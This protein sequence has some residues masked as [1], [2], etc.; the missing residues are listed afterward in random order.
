MPQ[1]LLANVTK[2]AEA[3]F[4]LLLAPRAGVCHWFALRLHSKHEFIVRDILDARGVENFLPTWSERV[5][6]SDRE[7]VT[8]RPLF[9]GYIFAVL[10]DSET[11][12]ASD[13]IRIPGVVQILPTSINPISISDAEIANLR[14]V[15]ASQVPVAP[16]AYVAGETVLIESGPLAGVSGVVTRTKGAY[17]LVVR[18]PMLMSAVNVEIGA[19]TVAKPPVAKQ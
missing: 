3:R 2:A 6:W 11:F 7:K 4:P 17:R 9:P 12:D 14:L 13:A 19:D 16:C 1:S 8:V 10:G 18:V 5:K 15:I